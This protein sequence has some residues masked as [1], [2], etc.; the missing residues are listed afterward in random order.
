MNPVVCVYHF[1]LGFPFFPDLY[2][3][4]GFL[5]HMV[6]LFLV[7]KGASILLSI[8]VA[9]IYFPTNNEVGFPFLHTF[10]SFYY[11]KLFGAS[12]CDW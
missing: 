2:P 6:V 1:K 11:C 9:P 7:F 5:D 10:S 3:G 12:H 4:V 8:V